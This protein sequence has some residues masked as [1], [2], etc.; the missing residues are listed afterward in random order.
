[1][2][3]LLMSVTWAECW[4]NLPSPH[5]AHFISELLPIVLAADIR[6][7]LWSGQAVC[8][9]CDNAA[10]LRTI[11]SEK[12]TEPLVLQCLRGLHLMQRS[13]LFVSQ[14]L[15]EVGVENGAADALLRN[16]AHLF[17]I[18][19]PQAAQAHTPCR[20][21]C[22]CSSSQKHHQIGYPRAGGSS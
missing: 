8:F 21:V 14:Q 1:M 6:G 11:H 17:L 18:Q 19:V 5:C 22:C 20:R 15:K 2:P 4:A 16:Q 12:S 13:T 7:P 3:T 10:I 9:H